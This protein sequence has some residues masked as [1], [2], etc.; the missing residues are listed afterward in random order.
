[1]EKFPILLSCPL[2]AGM[3]GPELAAFLGALPYT[4]QGF[5]PG[6]I[7]LDA[8]ERVQSIGILLEG[9]AEAQKTSPGGRPFTVA[10][11][12]PGSVYGDV[13]SGSG[14]QSPVCITARTSCHC[15]GLPYARL[16]S[17]AFEEA[18]PCHSLFLKN[19]LRVISEK[20]F[21]LD[22]RLDV[23]LIRGLRP[24]ISAWLLGEAARRGSASFA[25]GHTHASLAA[26][27]GCERSALSRELSR[28]AREGLIA[29]WRGQFTLLQPEALRRA[30]G[31]G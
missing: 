19:L 28:M 23:L 5:A 26:A 21:A 7:L 6:Q 12:G 24:R 18:T 11:L 30:A 10:Q 8:G 29:T 31:Q 9:R 20:Y 22:A 27:L 25:S 13:L 17:P 2:F 15:L 16:F 1:M 4:V 14:A 3:D